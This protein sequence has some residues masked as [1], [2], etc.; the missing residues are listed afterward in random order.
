MWIGDH[1]IIHR[2][3]DIVSGDFYWTTIYKQ[4]VVFCVADCTG[5][6][7]PG[8]FM[9]MLCISLLNEIVIKDEV[10]HPEE[11]LNKVR[12]MII[13]SLKQKGLMGEQKDGMDISICIYNKET[14]ELEFSGANN[15]LYIIRNKDNES[16]LCDKQLEQEDYILYEIRGDRMPI[17]I[18]DKMDPF[19]RNTINLLKNDR[20]YLFSDGICDQFGGPN[21]RRFMN[22]CLKAALMETLT[23]EIKD[24]KIQIEN[25][26]DEWQAFINPKTGHP[27]KQ[28]DD[29]CLMGLRI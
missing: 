4:Y 14:S 12:I 21:N 8:A 29:I 13:E 2:P 27:F 15:P 11:I 10:I 9:S 24:Q 7:V 19:K 22:N 16:I 28:V 6:G 26:I 23:P 20:L 1:F 25:R 3:K 5:H 17:S 18:Y